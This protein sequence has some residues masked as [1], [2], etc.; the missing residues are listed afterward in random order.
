MQSKQI[1]HKHEYFQNTAETKFT[2]H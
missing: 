1:M 2:C